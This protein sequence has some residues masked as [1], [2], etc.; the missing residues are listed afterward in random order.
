MKLEFQDGPGLNPRFPLLNI[1]VE[2]T[3]PLKTKTKE[4]LFLASNTFTKSLFLTLD[5]SRSPEKNRK[6]ALANQCV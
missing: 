5:S 1:V 2:S 4:D 6:K 3:P